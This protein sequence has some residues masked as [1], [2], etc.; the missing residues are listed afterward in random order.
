M[1]VLCNESRVFVHTFANAVFDSTLL[2]KDEI[3]PMDIVA[4]EAVRFA[5]VD[6][7]DLEL[8]GEAVLADR[9]GGGAGN[10]FIGR[11][12]AQDNF[13]VAAE[14]GNDLKLLAVQLNV[15]KLAGDG[16]ADADIVVTFDF[17]GAALCF[18]K[19]YIVESVNGRDVF[20]A[21]AEPVGITFYICGDL[22]AQHQ[23]DGVAG[24]NGGG[25]GKRIP[26]IVGDIPFVVFDRGII[27]NTLNLRVEDR[28]IAAFGKSGENECTGKDQCEDYG[29]QFLHVFTPLI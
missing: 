24:V 7:T 4:R 3:G 6:G 20:D 16:E 28:L 14:L 5:L 12:A 11:S 18:N 27:R 15:G 25:V 29:N 1:I 13:N 2:N 10:E 8:S 21:R 22:I 9:D 26:N 23:G 19:R 17:S